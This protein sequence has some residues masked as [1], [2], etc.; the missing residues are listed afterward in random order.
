[1]NLDEHFRG[2]KCQ[3]AKELF[4]PAPILNTL[5]GLV[6]LWAPI[7]ILKHSVFDDIRPSFIDSAGLLYVLAGI[8]C[9]AVLMM[10]TKS[11]LPAAL[12]AIAGTGA[13]VMGAESVVF[14]SLWIA[15]CVS[16]VIFQFV[17]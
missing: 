12:L 6:L 4:S 9:V 14:V 13:S 17:R 3:V 15:A 11:L 7:L 8:S 10:S 5:I 16:S 1:M 2:L